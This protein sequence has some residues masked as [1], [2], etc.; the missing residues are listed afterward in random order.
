MDRPS[1][2]HS[3]SALS[4]LPSVD[5]LLRHASIANL[6][7]EFP[8][9]ELLHCIRDVL[10]ERRAA[11]RS[12]RKLDLAVPALALEIRSKLH[13]RRRPHLRRVVNATGVVLH[14]GLGRAPLSADAVEAITDIAGAYSNLEYDLD[15]GR[16]GD[17]QEHTR[18]LLR[19]L[20]GAEDALVVNNNAAATFLTLNSLARG[21]GVIVSR[22]QLVEI[23]GSYRMPDIMAA[24]GCRMVEVGTTNRTHLRDYEHAIDEDMSILLHVH[25]SNYRIRG[26]VTAPEI[27]EL[28]ELARRT[29]GGQRCPPH[30][31]DLVVVDDLGSGLLLPPG[32]TGT[33]AQRHEDAKGSVGVSP[34]TGPARPPPDPRS[35][36]PDFGT[37]DEPDVRESIQSGADVILF[38]GDKL[39]GGPQAG[40]ILGRAE[41][42]ARLRQN[43]L[44]RTFRP[45]KLTLAALEATL[46]LYRDP[47]ALHENIPALRMLLAGDATLRQQADGLAAAIQ[48]Q[49][50][51][52][53][54]ESVQDQSQAGGGSLPTVAFPTWAVRVQHPDFT[55]A[56]LS[57]ALRG[58]DVPIVAR[59]KDGALLFDCRTLVGDDADEIP[60]AL[61][62]TVRELADN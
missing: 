16:R 32:S 8:R 52:A 43:P 51:G 24:A 4:D 1:A 39:L 10:D 36:I 56:V 30:P 38:S 53:T 31:D 48:R 28:V 46:R 15:T 14:T 18:A 61:A 6:L 34:A 37:W 41:L 33:N 26:F 11:L 45:D 47:Q 22:G 23:G 62:E 55:A 27:G 5:A 29:S 7:D 25:T 40:V 19:E 12:G 49:L 44:M 59:I 57:D 13:A 42:L 54:V 2:H 60:I 21:R 3:A 50:P 58:R 9:S 20:T 35:P 17:R